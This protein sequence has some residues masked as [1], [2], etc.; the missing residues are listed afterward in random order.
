[1]MRVVSAQLPPP[2]RTPTSRRPGMGKDQRRLL[3]G[4]IA[5]PQSGDAVNPSVR[6]RRKRER[7]GHR[8]P[9][10]CIALPGRSGD[11]PRALLKRLEHVARDAAAPRYLETVRPGPLPHGVRLLT[12]VGTATRSVR[13]GRSVDGAHATRRR[14]ELSQTFPKPVSILLRQVDLV[15]PTI[16]G[17]TDCL[18]GL[19]SVDVVNESSFDLLRHAS[20]PFAKQSSP[21]IGPSASAYRHVPASPEPTARPLVMMR[22]VQVLSSAN[23]WSRQDTARIDAVPH[24]GLVRPQ[25]VSAQGRVLASVLLVAAGQP[26]MRQRT[27]HES[28]AFLRSMHGS[29]RPMNNADHGTATHSKS[30]PPTEGAGCGD[31]C[32]WPGGDESSQYATL[33]A[34]A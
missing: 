31:V 3:Y 21:I 13:S 30:A 12:V 5:R 18:D 6:S 7:V 28:T 14:D 26:R 2:T 22:G 16:D 17:K 33:G 27:D 8:R 34:A 20:L 4:W 9:P 29:V 15:L 23:P 32:R 1:V 25:H 24:A 10:L 11:L 19:G